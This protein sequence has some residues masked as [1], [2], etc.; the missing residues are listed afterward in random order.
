MIMN[1]LFEDVFVIWNR[2]DMGSF[3]YK[4]SE[5]GIFFGLLF[6]EKVVCL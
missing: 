2:M 4:R 6:V 1:V 3:V 5:D